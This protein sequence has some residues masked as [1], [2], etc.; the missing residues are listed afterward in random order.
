MLALS[1]HPRI[2][3]AQ[4]ILWDPPYYK[5]MD[6]EYGEQSISRLNRSEYLAFFQRA[7]AM[8]PDTLSVIS[9]N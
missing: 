5:K 4:L 2:A 1:W 8:I 6:A 7:A 9:D 3:Q